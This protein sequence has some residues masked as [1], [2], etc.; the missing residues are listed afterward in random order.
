MDG[1]KGGWPYGWK[2]MGHVNRWMHEWMH[3]FCTNWFPRTFQIQFT[4]TKGCFLNTSLNISKVPC[5]SWPS[6]WS[7]LNQNSVSVS[8]FPSPS[9]LSNK[10]RAPRY[11]MIFCIS[12]YKP[13]DI[14]SGLMISHRNESRN[15]RHRTRSV[16]TVKEEHHQINSKGFWHHHVA[17]GWHSS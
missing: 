7:L 11:V 13:L 2:K 3:W 9:Q 1:S 8:C 10:S 14:V 6:K 5:L 4:L 17:W 12:G 16:K 15:L